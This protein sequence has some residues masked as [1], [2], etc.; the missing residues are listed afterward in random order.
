[1]SRLKDFIEV[2]AQY[3]GKRASIRSS[4]IEAVTEN[5]EDRNGE[6]VS[7]PCRTIWYAGKSIN[8]LESYDEILQMMYEAEF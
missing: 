8:V 1:M 4:C 5:A 6:R 7:F 2:T 3:D